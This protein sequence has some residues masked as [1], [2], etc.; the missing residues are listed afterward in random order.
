MTCPNCQQTLQMTDR[1][2]IEIDYCP[3]CR[4]VWLDRGELDKIL[5]R[6][7]AENRANR[8]ETSPAD[9]L[10]PPG[11]FGQQAERT[12]PIEPDRGPSR[13]DRDRFRRDRDDDDDDDPR[14]PRRRESFLE[15]VF[16][17]FD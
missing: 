17:V 3:Q 2:G 15:R 12:R 6:A 11:Y 1:L 8:R 4:G 9:E 14:R 13:P 5:E 10:L 16:D 7:G